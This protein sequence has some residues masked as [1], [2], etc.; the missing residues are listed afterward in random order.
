[1]KLFEIKRDEDNWLHPYQIDAC[2]KWGLPGV[3]CD[4]CG[5]VGGLGGLELPA[6][7]LPEGVDPG[8]YLDPSPVTPQRLAEL[9]APLLSAW[10]PDVP[11]QA[12]LEFGPLLGKAS[13]RAGD[14]AW[15][16]GC[17]ALLSN[18][19]VKRLRDA[20]V[21]SATTVPALLKWRGKTARDYFELQIL[22]GLRLA[23]SYL[24][25]WGT[26][27]P[28]SVCGMEPSPELSDRATRLAYAEWENEIVLDATSV[29]QGNWDLLRIIQAEPTIIASERFKSA[30]VDLGLTDIAFREVKVDL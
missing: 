16:G 3:R 18:S 2:H 21:L 20:G 12:G 6:L 10:G 29:P 11:L 7:S 8:P 28:C 5:F 9:C 4:R 13:G 24:C 26:P 23:P 27:R 22:P 14:V 30:A 15:A 25:R 19:A 17:T 1:M